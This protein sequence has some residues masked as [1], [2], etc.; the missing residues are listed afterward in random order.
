ME[1]RKFK[2]SVEKRMYCTGVV[3]VVALDAEDAEDIIT[4]KIASG[5]LKPEHVQWSDPQ[6]EDLSFGS[7]GDVD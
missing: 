5:Q 7:T 2:V 6:Y 1:K 4:V 3:E